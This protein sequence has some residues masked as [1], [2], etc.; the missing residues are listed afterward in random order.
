VSLERTSEPHTFVIRSSGSYTT[1]PSGERITFTTNAGGE[2]TG[3]ESAP[4]ARFAADPALPS[5]TSS[6]ST[7]VSSAASSRTCAMSGWSAARVRAAAL[8]SI[9]K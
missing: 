8:R 2:I 7:W 4:G 3:Y 5:R 1:L 9:G 6:G